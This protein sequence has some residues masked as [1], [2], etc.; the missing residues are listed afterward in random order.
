MLTATNLLKENV[1]LESVRSTIQGIVGELADAD[2]ISTPRRNWTIKLK[3]TDALKPGK[4][5]GRIQLKFSTGAIN[6][7]VL[8]NVKPAIQVVPER[9]VMLRSAKPFEVLSAKLE[10]AEGS[11]EPKRLT[12]GKW[13]LRIVLDASTVR[14]GSGLVA[15]TS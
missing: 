8:G 1:V 10:N 15:G 12:D 11:V 6:I 5:N 7:P 3:A 14:P 13:Q 2:R 9:L 4:L